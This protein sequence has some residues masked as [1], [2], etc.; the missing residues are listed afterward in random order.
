MTSA[1]SLFACP[2][3]TMEQPQDAP[4]EGYVACYRAGHFCPPMVATV[5]EDAQ[6]RLTAYRCPCC[7]DHG[8]SYYEPRE[9]LTAASC[10]RGASDV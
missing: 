4:A 9:W 5:E 8:V 7:G 10:E 2:G 6:G 3:I 1:S